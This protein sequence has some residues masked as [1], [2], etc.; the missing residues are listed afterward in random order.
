[1]REPRMLR[2][3]LKPCLAD[4]KCKTAWLI[5][6]CLTLTLLHSLAWA[7][8]QFQQKKVEDIPWSQRSWEQKMVESTYD[9]EFTNN[10]R[11][12]FNKD[13]FTWAVSKE[14]AERFG[15]P[16]RMIDPQLR[17]ALA[18]A[19]RNISIG[20]TTCGYG[21]DV[22]ACWPAFTCQ[23]D[24]YVDSATPIPWRFSDVQRDFFWSGVSSLDYVPMRMPAP[25]RF[26]YVGYNSSL[27]SKGLPFYSE[28]LRSKTKLYT[29][30]D[31][32]FRLVY[33]NRAYAPGVTLLG[34]V[35]ACPDPSVE[36]A[37]I[38]RF[39]SQEEQTRTRGRIENYAHVIEFSQA[40]MEKIGALHAIE[41][42]KM[43]ELNTAYQQ[44]M[45]K[46]MPLA[47]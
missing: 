30:N 7:D 5:V 3:S 34:F 37:A 11:L 26:R 44:V 17:G 45:K 15:M 32:T 40:L 22:N 47:K 29:A 4:A 46:Y 8:D 25:R 6:Q 35:S 21:G 31:G 36:D 39:Y 18:V 13:P 16:A 1:M 27:G 19:W 33:F 24:I 12:L 10:N 20:A 23:M 41:N 42:E 28:G 14:F 43:K 9:D 2:R 38:L